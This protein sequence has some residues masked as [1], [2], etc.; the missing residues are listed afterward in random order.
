MKKLLITAFILAFGLTSFA[1]AE[2]VTTEA[3]LYYNL[4]VD[5]YKVG[6]YDKSME[7]FRKAIELDP[8]Y[9]D[10]YFNLGSILEYLQQYD[11]ALST[12]KQIIVRNPNDYE[13]TYKA[14][15][16]SAKLKQIDNAKSYLSIIPPNAPIY[17]KAQELAYTLNS[18][19]QTIKADQLKVDS[20]TAKPGIYEEITSPTGITT[21]KEGNLY[22]A[23]FSDNIVYKITNDGR[24]LVFLKDSR[25]NGPIGMASDSDDNIYIANYNNNNV[26]KVGKNG[27]VSVLLGNVQKPYGLHIGG[28]ILY[29]SSQ[30]SNSII[31][32]K[33]AE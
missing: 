8:N 26:L 9:T 25:L 19:M 32:Y 29:I 6:L 28:N 30:G 17:Q 13:A 10:A 12:F 23:G 18:D 14:A 33:I 3:K 7:A 24:R 27:Y 16:L 5:H 20:E 31:K 15:Y 1:A 21:D 4:G 2:D 22:V 11:A